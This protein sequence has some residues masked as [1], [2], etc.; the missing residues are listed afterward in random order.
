M[1]LAEVSDIKA[2]NTFLPS[3]IE[4]FNARFGKPPFD[5]GRAPNFKR[6]GA[7]QCGR[8]DR[9]FFDGH[10]VGRPTSLRRSGR[11]GAYRYQGLAHR[12]GDIDRVR[13]IRMDADGISTHGNVLA[14]NAFSLAFRDRAPAA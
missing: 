3:S 11:S 2:G 5:L 6:S 1:R 12:A 13:R 4:T 9:C 8:R 10:Q 14:V 7:Y